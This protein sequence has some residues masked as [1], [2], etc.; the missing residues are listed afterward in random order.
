MIR[1]LGILKIF[2]KNKYK[3]ISWVIHYSDYSWMYKV[4]IGLIIL[5]IATVVFI[6]LVFSACV[7][8]GVFLAVV[9]T[10][11]FYDLFLCDTLTVK[12]SIG[13]YYTSGVVFICLTLIT[14]VLAFPFFKWI[15]SN[16]K[17]AISEYDNK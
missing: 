9:I 2:F 16:W 11:Y 7:I 15:Y 1:L 13:A 8:A 5:I 3:E 6:S 4:P 17:Q 10:P 14:F 12:T